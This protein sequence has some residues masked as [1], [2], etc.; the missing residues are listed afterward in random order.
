MPVEL[1]EYSKVYIAFS[2]GIDSVVLLHQLVQQHNT[3]I[4]LIHIHHNLQAE[5]DGWAIFATTTADQYGIECIIEHAQGKPSSGESTEAW[6]REQRYA[7]FEKHLGEG[8]ALVTAHH[9][10]DQAETVL[11]NLVRGSGVHGLAGM[12]ETRPLGQGTVVRPLLNTSRSDIEAYAQ[13]HSLKWVED[14]TNTDTQFARNFMRH[15]ILPLLKTRWPEVAKTM[16]R[17]A[18]HCA[19]ADATCQSRF[20]NLLCQTELPLSGLQTYSHPDQCAALQYWLC[21]QGFKPLSSAQLD[22]VLKDFTA[23]ACDRNPVFDQG[24]K[25]LYRYREI[26]AVR[27]VTSAPDAFC[28]PWN[29]QASLDIPGWGQPLTREQFIRIGIHVDELDW[30][31]ITVRSRVGGEKIQ[32][33]QQRTSFKKY[34]QTHS[35][36]PVLRDSVVMLF[37]NECC[38]GAVPP[39]VNV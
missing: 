21:A 36:A 29:G 34:C 32:V 27:D 11:L 20:E 35:I 3:R 22:T 6:A 23:A 5:A 31:K 12:P 24:R 33:G 2:G 7:L 14:P 4:T 30:P 26:L 39:G 19:W 8:D 17:T 25:Q 15:E 13:Q 9:Q 10:D 28:V 37:E 16:A 1:A 18:R 38:V